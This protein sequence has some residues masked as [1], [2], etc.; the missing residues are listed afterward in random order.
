LIAKIDSKRK[1]AKLEA[2][3]RIVSFSQG[4]KIA[5]GALISMI[6]TTKKEKAN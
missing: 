4:N 1:V 6:L 3:A 2:L 5:L